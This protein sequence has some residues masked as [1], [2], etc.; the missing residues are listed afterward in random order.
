[1]SSHDATLQIPSAGQY[2]MRLYGQISLIL[3][4]AVLASAALISYSDKALVNDTY[5]RAQ[6]LATML[7]PYMVSA[8][9][10]AI[11][12]LAVM[13]MVPASRDAETIEAIVHRL[14]EMSEGDLNGRAKIIGHGRL[15]DIAFEMNAASSNLSN[16]ITE[17]K[18]IDR[19]Q[20]LTLCHVRMAIEAGNRDEALK[21]ITM[22]EE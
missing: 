4:S 6:V 15:R 20:W 13:Q 3:L 12:A 9:I 8:I 14:Q 17:W 11:T 16:R 10:A 5:G 21:Y 7:L 19:Q 2:R 22:M 18:L 1:M